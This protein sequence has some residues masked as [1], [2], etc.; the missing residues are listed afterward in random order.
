[1][2]RP[3]LRSIRTGDEVDKVLLQEYANR[4]KKTYQ[5]WGTGIRPWVEDNVRVEDKALNAYVP[6]KLWPYQ[7]KGLQDALTVGENG[8]LQYLYVFWCWPRGDSKSFMAQMMM[9]WRFFNKANQKIILGSSSKE[10]SDFLHLNE[11]ANLIKNSPMLLNLLGRD[12][13]QEKGIYFPSRGS[14][15]EPVSTFSG[16]RSGVN[17]VSF[18]E[19]H[20]LKKE[21]FWIDLVTSTRAVPNAQVLVDTTASAEGHILHRMWRNAQKGDAAGK[22]IYF[23]Y[24]CDQNQSP[25]VTPQYLAIQKGSLPKPDYDRYFRNRWGSGGG[26]MFSKRL[27][28]AGRYLGTKEDG[29]DVDAF[30]YIWSQIDL[31]EE[32]I[33]RKEQKNVDGRAIMHSRAELKRL[34]S[35]L[36]TVDEFIHLGSSRAEVRKLAKWLGTDWCNISG[37]LDRALPFSENGD[38]TVW[39]VNGRFLLGYEKDIET[40]EEVPIFWDILLDL[41]VVEDSDEAIIKEGIFWANKEYEI[42]HIVMEDYQTA[43]IRGWCEN[44]AISCELIQANYANQVKAFTPLYQQLMKYRLKHPFASLPILDGYDKHGDEYNGNIYEVEMVAFEQN[45]HERKFGSPTK[46][47]VGGVKDDAVYSRAWAKYASSELIESDIAGMPV[48]ASVG[49]AFGKY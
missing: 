25:L 29:P 7:V 23:N 12:N 6:V 43:D 46:A 27:V 2:D 42:E 5:E 18:T 17:I 47:S 22:A 37:G 16:L 21:K 36:V 14:F 33:S 31:L 3:T 4:F 49:G 40:D 39:S 24:I 32:D 15:I 1:V 11:M 30:K 20:E 9:L 41:R 44:Q 34:Y 35:L 48:K 38:R 8:L 45:P 10:N 19:L 28:L 13:V 26:K